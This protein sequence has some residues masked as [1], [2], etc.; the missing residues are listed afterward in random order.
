MAVLTQ[1][2]R[3]AGSH[4]Q[5]G[6]FRPFRHKGFTLVE[7]AIV[8]VIV[9]LLIGGMLVPLAAQRDLQNTSETQKQLLD[10]KDALLGFAAANG[11]LP[12][13]DTDTDPTAAGYGLEEATCTASLTEEGYLPWKTLGVNPLDSWGSQRA[14]STSPRIGDWRYRVDRNFAQ[15]F[16]ISTGFFDYSHW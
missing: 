2:F 11:R 14:T 9:A 3:D 5:N 1:R 6:P 8:L 10:I 7:L 16:T 12:C 4:Q 15:A 13:P